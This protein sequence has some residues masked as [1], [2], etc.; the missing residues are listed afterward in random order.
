M[1]YAFITFSAMSCDSS[2]DGKLDDVFDKTILS[3]G[4]QEELQAALKKPNPSKF[5]FQGLKGKNSNML[6]LTLGDPDFVRKDGKGQIWQ[7]RSNTCILDIFL[8]GLKGNQIITHLEMRNRTNS[9]LKK[10][11]QCI[12]NL[13]INRIRK[14][15]GSLSYNEKI[16]LLPERDPEVGLRQKVLLT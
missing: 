12:T 13:I 11:D 16:R 1:I 3:R 10:I 14:N 6:L 5:V 8:Y 7:Y 15:S 9:E 2:L 4:V